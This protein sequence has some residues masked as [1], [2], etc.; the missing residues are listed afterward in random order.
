MRR[1]AL[2]STR[3]ACTED[4]GGKGPHPP[5]AR[6]RVPHPSIRG[7]IAD[8]R[9]RTNDPATPSDVILNAVKDTRGLLN[10]L[11]RHYFRIGN[12]PTGSLIL[13][14]VIDSKAKQR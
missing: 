14:T 2:R 8:G 12:N 1:A 5:A 13:L 3:P 11:K 7:L 6:R 9:E 10:T 4:V